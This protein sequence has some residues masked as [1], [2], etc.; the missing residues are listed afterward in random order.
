MMN[1]GEKKKRNFVTKKKDE[2][3]LCKNTKTEETKKQR[4][5]E[6]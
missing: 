5:K 6:R 3:D 4:N 1:P 2:K